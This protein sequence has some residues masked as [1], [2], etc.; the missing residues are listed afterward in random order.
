MRRWGHPG[1]TPARSTRVMCLSPG[2]PLAC[3]V[4]LSEISH[5]TFTLHVSSAAR[6]VGEGAHVQRHEWPRERPGRPSACTLAAAQPVAQPSHK[7]P[8]SPLRTQPVGE[9]VRHVH[10]DAELRLDGRTAP[11]PCARLA[12]CRDTHRVHAC[13]VSGGRRAVGQQE[14]R[15]HSCWPAHPY[16]SSALQRFFLSADPAPRPAP[17]HLRRTTP[18][19]SAPG[20]PGAWC[21]PGRRGSRG[22]GSGS[23][24]RRRT[25]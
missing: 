20:S 14:T 19:T 7:Q 17:P 5:S 22:A 1:P 11:Y 8:G 3:G 24:E 10:A 9:E 25:W 12:I 6:G 18:P 23:G 21:A 4:I 16:S 13:Q 2:A 15:G